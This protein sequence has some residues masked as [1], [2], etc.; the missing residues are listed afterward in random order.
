MLSC[1]QQLSGFNMVIFYS[2]DIFSKLGGGVF[3]SRIYTC[4]LGLVN[5]TASMASL[6]VIDKVGRKPLMVVG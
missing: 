1:L 4:I 5:L 6:Q 2:N 3:I